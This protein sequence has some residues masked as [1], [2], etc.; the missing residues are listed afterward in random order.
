MANA[1]IIRTMQG[2]TVDLICHR[3]YGQTQHVTEAVYQAN[4]G[5]AALGP[6]LPHGQ[7]INLPAIEH[8]QQGAETRLNLWD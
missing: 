4:P 8:T 5:L 3:Y 7:L 6:I 1:Q 2:D